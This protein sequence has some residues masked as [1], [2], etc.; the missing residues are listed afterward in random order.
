[1]ILYAHL[2]FKSFYYIKIYDSLYL[3]SFLC[4]LFSNIFPFCS[5]YLLSSALISFRTK[6]SALAQG[7]WISRQMDCGLF[8][9]G[10]GCVARQLARW[11]RSRGRGI[12]LNAVKRV[13]SYCRLLIV[14]C[15]CWHCLCASLAIRNALPWAR[16]KRPEAIN[17]PRSGVKFN[18]W[19]RC[20]LYIRT[21]RD[22][23]PGRC[24]KVR[25]TWVKLGEQQQQQEEGEEAGA[26][27]EAGKMVSNR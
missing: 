26:G 19:Q 18:L 7:D 1:M 10:L 11:R 24:Q 9:S 3:K 12:Y 20:M 8:R 13:A 22:Q 6:L 23:R 4:L 5:L 27:P 21:E 16:R 25:H 17:G 14:D 15:R 2:L